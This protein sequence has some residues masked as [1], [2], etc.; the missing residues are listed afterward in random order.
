MHKS[1]LSRA[2]SLSLATFAA[3]AT[4]APAAS[5]HSNSEAV[6]VQDK[7]QTD[8]AQSR[9]LILAQGRCYNGRCY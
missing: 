4:L 2:V 9:P 6:P 3:V 5:R 7:V 8:Q 1:L